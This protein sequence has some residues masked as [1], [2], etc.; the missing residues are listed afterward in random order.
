[1]AM[2]LGESTIDR[3]MR[4]AMLRQELVG[5]SDP[6]VYSALS[7]QVRMCEE[8]LKDIR[9]S[10]EMSTAQALDETF[11]QGGKNALKWLAALFLLASIAL[12]GAKAVLG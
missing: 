9:I 10:K 11:R 8:M 5:D 6:N 7:A 4:S 2:T 12:F 1:M 3:Y